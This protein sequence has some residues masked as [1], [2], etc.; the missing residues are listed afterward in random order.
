VGLVSYKIKPAALRAAYD[1]V[2]P[3]PTAA[4][5][6]EAIKISD[7]AMQS[8]STSRCYRS[9]GSRGQAEASAV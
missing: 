6:A 2:N 9:S 7:W 5:L 3:R 8:R 1:A 4:A